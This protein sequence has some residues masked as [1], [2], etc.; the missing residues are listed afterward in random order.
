MLEK[1]YLQINRLV[2]VIV[3]STIMTTQKV[4]REAFFLK[5]VEDYKILKHIKYYEK[6]Y[7][8]CTYYQ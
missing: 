1:N 2:I 8:K 5:V 4:I 6:F 7:V 3:T